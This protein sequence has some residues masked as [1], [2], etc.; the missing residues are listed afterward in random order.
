[1]YD[2]TDKPQNLDLETQE[3]SFLGCAR[4]DDLHLSFSNCKNH[5]TAH[6]YGKL[7]KIIFLTLQNI[8][9]HKKRIGACNHRIGPERTGSEVITGSD[10]IFH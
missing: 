2:N 9:H 6:L 7:T 3:V 1:M 5:D 4:Y 8:R 10:L